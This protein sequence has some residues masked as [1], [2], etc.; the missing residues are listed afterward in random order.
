MNKFSK[1]LVA[2]VM[3]GALLIPAGAMAG[4]V[5]ASSNETVSLAD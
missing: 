4:E 5:D 3:C 2:L 1:K